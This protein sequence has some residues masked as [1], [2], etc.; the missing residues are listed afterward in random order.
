MLQINT[1]VKPMNQVK[2]TIKLSTIVVLACFTITAIG[3]GFT[4]N[5]IINVNEYPDHVGI[6]SMM[7]ATT[8]GIGIAIWSKKRAGLLKW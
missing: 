5:G 7:F 8:G 4:V 3:I 1:S 6:G 2:L